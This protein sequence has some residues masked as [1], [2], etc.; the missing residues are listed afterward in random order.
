MPEEL[1]LG[2]FPQPQVA[3][4]PAVVLAMSSAQHLLSTSSS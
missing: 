4:L 2:S 3:R 1:P